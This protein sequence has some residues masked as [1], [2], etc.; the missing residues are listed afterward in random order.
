MESTRHEAGAEALPPVRSVKILGQLRECL[1]CQ[2]CSSRT[3][4]LISIWVETPIR[5]HRV[6]L[7]VLGVGPV[8]ARFAA[9]GL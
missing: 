3:E 1:R 2:R 4:Q 6:A 9:S 5:F 8:V 7:A